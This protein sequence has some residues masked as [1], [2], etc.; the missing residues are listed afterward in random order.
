MATEGL[1]SGAPET[2][3]GSSSRPSAEARYTPTASCPS[4][5]PAPPR[6]SSS[7]RETVQWFV[8]DLGLL[9]PVACQVTLCH[10]SSSC[11]RFQHH[12]ECCCR[13]CIDHVHTVSSPSLLKFADF[14]YFLLTK[15]R[16]SVSSF[17]GYWAMLSSC[18]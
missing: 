4:V 15:K 12:W 17:K 10:R 6:A 1:V 13:W 7:C 9:L 5:S 18:F 8:R 11:H 2:V 16:L 3:G 14:L